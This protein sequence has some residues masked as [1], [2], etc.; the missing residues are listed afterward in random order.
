MIAVATTIALSGCQKNEIFENDILKAD[1]GKI[2]FSSI[3]NLTTRAAAGHAMGSTDDLRTLGNFKVVGYG[4]EGTI[5]GVLYVMADVKYNGSTWEYNNEP[6]WPQQALNF[7]AYAPMGVTNG[8]ANGTDVDAKIAATGVSKPG[9]TVSNE[10]LATTDPGNSNQLDFVVA[11]ELLKTKEN[12]TMLR[13]KHAL[14]QINFKAMV[15]KI[16]NPDDQ[17]QVSIEEV[18]INNINS[19]GDFAWNVNPAIPNPKATATDP[20]PTMMQNVWSEKGTPVNYSA[21]PSGPFMVSG[22]GAVGTVAN[23]VRIQNGAND[24]NSLLMIPQNFN[25]WNT[26]TRI[27]ENDNGDKGAYVKL[28]AKIWVKRNNNVVM[29]HGKWNA[30]KAGFEENVADTALLN[31]LTNWDADV[32]YI[33][34]SSLGAATNDV[35]NAPLGQWV[36]GRNINYI[37]TFGDR[38]S[39]SGGGGWTD[40]GEDKDP[41]QVLVPIKFTATLE[42]W[43]EQDVP[44]LT[45][46]VTSSSDQ[47]VDSGFIQ[48][49][50]NR[51]MTDIHGTLFPKTFAS[52]VTVTAPSLK[53]DSLT[54][55]MS[56]FSDEDYKYFRP[57]ST[58]TWE[59]TST[60]GGSIVLPDLTT[61]G[62]DGAWSWSTTT[63]ALLYQGT[64][65]ITLTAGQSAKIVL[66]KKAQNEAKFDSY[67][68][69]ID[70][71]TLAV[72]KNIQALPLDGIKLNYTI[73]SRTAEVAEDT[74]FETGYLNN[75]VVNSY[76]VTRSTV[77]EDKIKYDF[78]A[79]TIPEKYEIRMNIPTGWK[80]DETSVVSGFSATEVW[81]NNDKTQVG[82]VIFKRGTTPA[83]TTDQ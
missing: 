19:V 61:L 41:E 18:S 40:N 25:A 30:T 58:F 59:I 26:G 63:E 65:N 74:Y 15:I 43:V 69:N 16:A 77:V 47:P 37:I 48:G 14:T 24:N 50:T 80:L 66:V 78:T 72:A 20:N 13:F 83:P 5:A 79:V 35:T 10:N 2:R 44:L 21:D 31:N 32:I 55:G 34:V 38:T 70:G 9:F 76:P 6:Y 82:I 4:T 75:I 3:Q 81:V 71:F 7:M 27:S 8:T 28:K 67:F 60:A 53:N 62:L 51:V 57:G 49:Y 52:K 36:P 39:G 64:R 12:R 56:S 46:T 45:S 17:L 22:V 54:L 42:D 29:L 68:A 73:T 33:P 1:D 23:A 11:K